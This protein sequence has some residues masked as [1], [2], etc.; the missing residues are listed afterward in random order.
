MAVCREGEESLDARIARLEAK[1]RARQDELDSIRTYTEEEQFAID[2]A[3]I[4][5]V[6]DPTELVPTGT[7]LEKMHWS[8]SPWFLV[9]NNRLRKL[10]QI[11]QHLAR[12]I[13]RLA[14]IHGLSTRGMEAGTEAAAPSVEAKS[15][16][17]HGRVAAAHRNMAEQ[18]LRY[19]GEDAASG[20]RRLFQIQAKQVLLERPQH[21]LRSL[22]NSLKGE[23]ATEVSPNQKLSFSDFRQEVGRAAVNGD[24]LD[25]PRDSAAARFVED[26]AREYRELFDS[27]EAEGLR[28]GVFKEGRQIQKEIAKRQAQLERLANEARRLQTAG[29]PGGRLE[30]MAEERLREA[31]RVETEIA[32]LEDWLAAGKLRDNEPYFHRMWRRDM[33]EAHE[34][35]FRELIMA[36]LTREAEVV[37]DGKVVPGHGS[38]QQLEKRANDVIAA[39]MREG[40][41][42]DSLGVLDDAFT[43]RLT[44]ELDTTTREL[45]TATRDRQKG[46]IKRAEQLRALIEESRKGNFRTPAALIGRNINIPNRDLVDVQVSTGTVSFIEQD[47]DLVAA[48]YTQR[49]APIVETAREFG[50]QRMT[51]YLTQ[52]QARI[53]AAISTMP[54]EVQGEATKESEKVIQAFRDLRDMVQ[55][56]YG[57]PENPDGYGVR[58]IRSLKGINV[59]AFMGKAWLSAVMDFGKVQIHEGVTRSFGHL[60]RS[61]AARGVPDNAYVRGAEEIQK[62]G[63]ADEL[64]NA[65]RLR[66]M[67]DLAGQYYGKTRLERWID[68]QVPRMFILNGLAF[69]TDNVKRF[70]GTLAIDRFLIAAEQIAGGT[71]GP[72]NMAKY[73]RAGLTKELAE[74]VM[75]QWTLAGRPEANGLRLADTMSWNDQRVLRDFRAVMGQ[76]INTAVITPGAA[77]RLLFTAKPVGSMLMQYKSFGISATQRILMSG[78]QQRDAQV[79]SGMLSMIALSWIVDWARRPDWDKPDLDEAIFRAVE[80]SGVAGIFAD[81]NQMLEVASGSEL[82]MRPL[83]GI[84]MIR[85][86]PTAGE[87]IGAIGGPVVNQWG[88]ALWAMT[89]PDATGDDQARALR[90][91]IPWN[92]VWMWAD[93]VTRGQIEAGNII[94]DF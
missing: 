44:Q 38:P 48:A 69:W 24:K 47:I 52:L 35:E 50:D 1:L 29:K 36:W 12:E 49:M 72:R 74:A 55:G 89:S 31:V 88:S 78:L 8:Q 58:A 64:V 91:S 26:S 32:E 81:V 82:G 79:L 30:Q 87:R 42:D 54:E 37:V 51:G 19:L 17:W 41:I 18:Y 23:A 63:L 15:W 94:E 14:G 2:T 34:K 9:K 21:A 11:G 4:D 93:A 20:T 45:V 77:D 73:A 68:N 5:G 86:D 13:D 62:I 57:L 90:Y 56:N 25:M 67:T 22:I 61:I 28:L 59:L 43:R 53:D 16:Q 6:I 46:L 3:P 10:G 60:F 27:F 65:T 76:E 40:E 83:L 33:I 39:I 92:N 85:K 66:S 80:R 7:K 71:M 84:D 70:A 75:D